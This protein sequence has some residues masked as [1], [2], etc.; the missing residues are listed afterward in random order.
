MT[1][2]GQKL[3]AGVAV[4]RL[5]ADPALI[6]AHRQRRA[7][8]DPAIGAAGVEAERGQPL[9]D[10]LDFGKRREGSLPGNFCTNGAPPTQRSPR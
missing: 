3:D 1:Q 5:D 2:A 8:P 9:L 4:G 6:V 10:F 7:K